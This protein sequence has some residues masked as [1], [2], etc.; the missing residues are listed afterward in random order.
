[1]KDAEIDRLI[2]AQKLEFDLGKRNEILK[3]IDHR[4]LEIAPYVLLWE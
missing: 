1:M 2:E 4:L 3:Q